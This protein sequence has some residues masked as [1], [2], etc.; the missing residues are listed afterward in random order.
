MSEHRRGVD[1]ADVV[2]ALQRAA[3]ADTGVDV[4]AL[5]AGARGRAR[6]IR[7]RRQGVAGVVAVFALAVPVGL[8]QWP[9]QL[10]TTVTPASPTATTNAVTS[11]PDGSLLTTQ[12]VTAVM[13]GLAPA[14]VNP[15]T[16]SG[17]CQD[18]AYDGTA[19][20]VDSRR[21]GWGGTAD[22]VSS[23]TPDAAQLDVLLFRGSA[24]EDWMGLTAQDAQDCTTDAP[25]GAE[26]TVTDAGITADEAVA[27]YA[28]Q[29]LSDSNP[30]WTAIV[31]ARTGQLVVRVSIVTHRPDGEAAVGQ[32]AQLAAAQL[33]KAADLVQAGG[34]PR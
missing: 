10:P 23:P 5:A 31:A 15:S 20:V 29:S 19:T 2:R 18:D 9:G 16:N 30:S 7:R 21:L 17:L 12:D 11:I 1:E 33:E 28:P 34:A 6:T 4:S 13:A 24:A 27:G 26:F 25:E 22:V 3:A 32:A 8:S 14:E